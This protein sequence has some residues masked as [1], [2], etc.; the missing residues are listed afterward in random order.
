MTITPRNTGRSPADWDQDTWD[1]LL[2][3]FKHA[4]SLD[5]VECAKFGA[6]VYAAGF[7]MGA[8]VQAGPLM[9]WE[10][11]EMADEVANRSPEPLRSV[12]R[13]AA[14]TTQGDRDGLTDLAM[15]LRDA[16]D[17][18]KLLA[19][20]QLRRGVDAETAF[21]NAKA[22]MLGVSKMS[23]ADAFTE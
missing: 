22:Q 7:I 13:K 3:V 6:S 8:A 23:A 2:E 10:L 19:T 12:V 15:A 14:L 4:W 9:S 21:L 20:G 11:A 17:V 5:P 18:C 16:A 1:G